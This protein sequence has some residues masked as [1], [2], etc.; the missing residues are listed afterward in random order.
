MTSTVSR[1]ALL[2][3][4]QD[5]SCRCELGRYL[6]ENIMFPVGRLTGFTQ[7]QDRCGERPTET[8]TKTF[9]D[10]DRESERERDKGEER[11]RKETEMELETE[12]CLASGKLRKMLPRRRSTCLPIH[13]SRRVACSKTQR[14]WNG[15][16]CPE[17]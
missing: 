15:C 8:K 6:Q 17:A 3:I 1:S 12:R 5:H 2:P 13:R 11:R 14:A 4:D 10:R 16:H 9:R 7:S